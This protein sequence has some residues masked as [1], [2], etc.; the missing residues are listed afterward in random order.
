[1]GR[2]TG[3][4]MWA[5]ILR[6]FAVVWSAGV[7]LLILAAIVGRFLAGPTVW[8]AVADIQYWFSPFNVLNFM[9]MALFFSPAIVGGWLSLGAYWPGGAVA[10]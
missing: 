3:H 6:G 4:E 2:Q 10:V 9:V 7:G 1:M 5:K 8:D